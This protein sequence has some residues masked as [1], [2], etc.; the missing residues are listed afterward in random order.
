MVQSPTQYTSHIP[1]ASNVPVSGAHGL[2]IPS[3]MVLQGGF[4][5]VQVPRSLA[6]GGRKAGLDSTG[7]VL[8]R[9]EKPPLFHPSAL[10]WP[11]LQG[12]LVQ[13]SNLIHQTGTNVRMTLPLDQ[14]TSSTHMCQAQC[15]SSK[16][17][18]Q[19]PFCEV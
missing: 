16:F 8:G 2:G 9:A 17:L 19:G 14:N 15:S 6:R 5:L 1:F 18:V 4:V 7:D 12:Q 11:C 10:A 13:F 3:L